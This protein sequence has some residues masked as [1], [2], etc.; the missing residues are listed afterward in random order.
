[1]LGVLHWIDENQFERVARSEGVGWN[2]GG[3][4]VKEVRVFSEDVWVVGRTFVWDV[5]GWMGELGLRKPSRRYLK[6]I[7]DGVRSSGLPEWYVEYV[8]NV[9]NDG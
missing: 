9:A 5:G 7:V 6:L 2:F 3:S 8:K 1:M 4:V